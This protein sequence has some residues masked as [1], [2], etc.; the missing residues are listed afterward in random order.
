MSAQIGYGRYVAIGDSQTEGL[1]DGDD[2]I[3]LRG[4]ADLLAARLDSLYPGLQYANLA[5]RGVLVS[6][7]L[8][9]QVP[10]ALAMQPDLV[11]VCAG[12]NDVIQPGRSFDRALA[13][14]ELIYSKLAESGAAVV[15]TTFPDVARFLPLGRV[16]SP[17]LA[18][19]NNAITAAADRYGFRLVD[20][21]NAPSMRD[22]D[23]WAF[24]RVHASTK[25]HV[26]FAAAAA[27]ALGLPGSGHGWAESRTPARRSLTIIAYGYLR[28]TQASFMPWIW[29]RMRGLSSAD[30]RSPKR[31]QLAPFTPHIDHPSGILEL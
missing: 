11:T 10:R 1:W 25:G 9:E 23:T 12:M 19:I 20:L 27:E 3:G 7:V 13:D 21:Y 30:G 17:R 14:L 2:H 29:R 4:F 15:T 31:P 22:L 8:R 26:L 18:R 28:W 16:V 24:D 6:D 5:I